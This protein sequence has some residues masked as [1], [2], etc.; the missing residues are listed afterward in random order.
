M[1]ILF[2]SIIALGIFLYI[3]HTPNSEIVPY[4]PQ[5][6]VPERIFTYITNDGLRTE[7]DTFMLQEHVEF[8]KQWKMK[9]SI[10]V[11]KLLF[12]ENLHKK[13]EIYYEYNGF[14]IT[15]PPDGS[16]CCV[17]FLKSTSDRIIAYLPLNSDI[18]TDK[19]YAWEI[20][21]NVFPEQ[22]E[23]YKSGDSIQ[24]DSL[25]HKCWIVDI[26]NNKCVRRRIMKR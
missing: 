9:D 1:T 6:Y 3:E 26:V 20:L 21:K 22:Y 13:Y 18:S 11:L 23:L 2:L 5:T 24:S 4:I 8:P 17:R 7:I 14:A 15:S 19:D 25:P 10:V 16:V 12:A